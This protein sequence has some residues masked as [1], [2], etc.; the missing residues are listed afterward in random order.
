MASITLNACNEIDYEI[1]AYLFTFLL[2]KGT[3]CATLMVNLR[4]RV[5]LATRTSL[6]VRGIQMK[7]SKHTPGPWKVHKSVYVIALLA[8]HIH[9]T[10]AD[11]SNRLIDKDGRK[12]NARLIAAAPKLLAAA[13]EAAKQLRAMEAIG[14]ATVLQNVIDKAI[15]GE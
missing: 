8:K 13:I 1:L 6:R 5:A 15:G 4:T 2:D 9:P 10:I 12:A 7:D 11:C 14:H 3:E